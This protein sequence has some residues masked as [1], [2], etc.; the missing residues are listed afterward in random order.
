[1]KRMM[2]EPRS[3]LTLCR[4]QVTQKSKDLLTLQEL[5]KWT[6]ALWMAALPRE[7]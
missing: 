6:L 3:S 5:P 7:N 4:T 1:M 2:L